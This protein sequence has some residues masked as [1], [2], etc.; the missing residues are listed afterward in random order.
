MP[1]VEQDD[2]LMRLQVDV[3]EEI[4][5]KLKI[6]AAKQGRTMSE[7]VEEALRDYFDKIAKASS[8]STPN[9]GGSAASE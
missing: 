5:T 7:I 1:A 6:E 8:L 2:P 4:K 3:A 9:Q